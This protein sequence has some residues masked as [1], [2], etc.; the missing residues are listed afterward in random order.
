MLMKGQILRIFVLLWLAWYVWGPLDPVFDYW[1]TPRQTMSDMERSA[2]GTVVLIA[3]VFVFASLQARKLRE[4]FHRS[5][6]VVRTAVAVPLDPVYGV[7]LALIPVQP[8]HS[9]PVSLR[10]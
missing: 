1:D 5:L 2:N 4:R 7:A 9:P 3:G 8:I 6:R 10:I